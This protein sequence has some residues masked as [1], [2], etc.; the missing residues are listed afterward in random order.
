VFGLVTSAL[1]QI[2][3]HRWQATIDDVIKEGGRKWEL[4]GH[5]DNVVDG[6]VINTGD[7]ETSKDEEF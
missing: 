2:T 1:L 5:A 4:D 3:S 6:L 7:A